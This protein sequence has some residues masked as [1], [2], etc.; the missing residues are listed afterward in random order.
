MIFADAFLKNSTKMSKLAAAILLSTATGTLAYSNQDVDVAA[1]LTEYSD[2]DW[3]ADEP[4]PAT[5][6]NGRVH[7][8]SDTTIYYNIP[9]GITDEPEYGLSVNLQGAS[10]ARVKFDHKH[11]A[12]YNSPGTIDL[13]HANLAG[14]EFINLPS[15][16]PVDLSYANLNGAHLYG[17]SGTFNVEGADLRNAD[18]TD[19]SIYDNSVFSNT[20]INSNTNF[21]N[22]EQVDVIS[23]ERT[24][25][26]LTGFSIVS[27]SSSSSS[28]L[29][30]ADCA[31]LQSTYIDKMNAGECQCTN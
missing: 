30:D 7:C 23:N 3:Q 28:S 9:L 5:G 18:L 4:N 16:L 12:D 11:S 13:S 1:F 15:M 22:T 29:A 21:D 19:A 17:A 20:K 24:P 2:C 14:V 27:S 26:L 10:L 8:A 31:D 6:S 25:F